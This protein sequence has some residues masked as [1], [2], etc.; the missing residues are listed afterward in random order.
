MN[1]ILVTLLVVLGPLAIYLTLSRKMREFQ[2]PPEAPTWPVIGHI[3]G[4]MRSKFNY[5]VTLR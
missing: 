5:Y 1:P 2:E 4:L 3:V